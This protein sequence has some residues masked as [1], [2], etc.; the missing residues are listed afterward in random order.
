MISAHMPQQKD[1]NWRVLHIIIASNIWAKK[2]SLL[3]HIEINKTSDFT[4]KLLQQKA[5]IRLQSINFRYPKKYLKSQWQEDRKRAE[6]TTV[7]VYHLRLPSLQFGICET[8]HFGLKNSLRRNPLTGRSGTVFQ[9]AFIFNRDVF[10]EHTSLK[11]TSVERIENRRNEWGN[12]MEISIN[13]CMWKNLDTLFSSSFFHFSSPLETW[14]NL[15]YCQRPRSARQEQLP[16]EPSN[17][18][19]PPPTGIV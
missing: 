10:T 19:Y 7:S 17:L 4:P 15:P 13:K 9:L 3:N 2:T 16:S 8:E 1:S 5:K 14:R 12:D 18:W 6:Y 11:R